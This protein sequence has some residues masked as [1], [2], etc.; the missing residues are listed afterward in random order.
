MLLLMSS[1]STID[2]A[3]TGHLLMAY[4]TWSCS[5]WKLV[6]YTPF[7]QFFLSIEKCFQG[8][9]FC[10]FFANERFARNCAKIS[11][12]YERYCSSSS[13]TFLSSPGKFCLLINIPIF[14][15][16]CS[17]IS[18]IIIIRLLKFFIIDIFIG[19]ALLNF[20][21]YSALILLLSEAQ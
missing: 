8:F 5:S 17:K 19:R 10:Y 21:Y 7:P 1:I 20:Y 14:H 16:Y 11:E 12:R 4:M 6:C 13:T 9:L 2:P 18:V 15:R 3:F